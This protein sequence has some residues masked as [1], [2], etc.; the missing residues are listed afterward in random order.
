MLK[1]CICIGVGGTAIKYGLV[2]LQGELLCSGECPTEAKCGGG[3]G[4]LKKMEDIV[5]GYIQEEGVVGIAISTAGMVDP[6]KGCIVY[7]LE[8][9]IPN[10]TGMGIK[11]HM[12][13][14]YGLR[15][16]V[17][18]DVNCMGLAEAWRVKDCMHKTITCFT[19]G[20]SI[21]GAIVHHGE[22]LSGASYS[23]GEVAYMRVPEGRLHELVSATRL[24]LDVAKK[25]QLPIESVNGKQIFAWAKEGDAISIESID[26]L[27]ERLGTALSNVISVLNPHAIILGG[28][29]M[30]QEEYIRPRLHKVLQEKLVPL[31]YEHTEI[32][33]ARLGNNAGMMGAF[34]HWMQRKKDADLL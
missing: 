12:E 32:H 33:F 30:A 23:A 9:A 1:K 20:T 11:Q 29:I 5:S 21:G 17:E 31:V 16:E 7:S 3:L 19:I 8:E 13:A 25:K 18:N 28:G 34:R 15:T 26:I 24:A 6:V 14:L 4:I 27:I 22:I 10:Y 2:T